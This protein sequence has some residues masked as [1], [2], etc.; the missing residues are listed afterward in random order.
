MVH[1]IT[2]IH[3]IMKT[4]LALI[5]WHLIDTQHGVMAVV[6][7]HTKWEAAE[8][9]AEHFDYAD[10]AEAYIKR[11]RAATGHNQLLNKPPQ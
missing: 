4:K 1:F 8:A 11:I 7:A 3:G 6:E 5:E 10:P 2:C 9:I